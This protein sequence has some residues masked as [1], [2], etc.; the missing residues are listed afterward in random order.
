M[1]V[2]DN[3]NGNLSFAL[4]IRHFRIGSRFVNGQGLD[5]ESCKYNIPHAQLLTVIG[6]AR[7][8]HQIL[9]SRGW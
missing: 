5:W 3:D 1:Y 6:H 8:P 2:S 4:L 7:L 9:V